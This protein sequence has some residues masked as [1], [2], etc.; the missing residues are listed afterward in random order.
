MKSM[1][2]LNLNRKIK[3][4]KDLQVYDENSALFFQLTPVGYDILYIFHNK[5]IV[6]VKY[7]V[8]QLLKEYEIEKEVL[9]RDII[10]FLNKL[11]E[12]E[13]INIEV[14]NKIVVGSNDS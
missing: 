3:V 13:I 8:E 10:I 12:L 6:S 4:R 14:Y 5:G 11:L 9:S 7:L 2:E 1:F